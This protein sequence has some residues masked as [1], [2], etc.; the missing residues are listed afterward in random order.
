LRL[1][2]ERVVAANKEVEA[3]NVRLDASVHVELDDCKGLAEERQKFAAGLKLPQSRERWW[4][5]P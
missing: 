3:F 1:I 2:E 5:R 4:G